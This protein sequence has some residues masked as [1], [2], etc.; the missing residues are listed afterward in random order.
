[1][2]S[3]PTGTVTFLFTDIEGSTRRWDR[4][5]K[6]MRLAL[7]RHD[8]LLQ[9]VIAQQGGHVF[10]TVG[11]AFHAAF[12]SAT[13]ALAGAV[14]VQRAL[15]VE[16]WTVF[17]ADLEPLRVRT[18]LHTGAAEL[19]DGDYFGPPLNRTARLL[20]AGHGGQI[21]L[22]LATQQLV[23]DEL[24]GDTQLQD[25]G[26]HRLKDLGHSE[27]IFRLVVQGLPDVV[28]PPDTAETL[29]AAERAHFDA[30]LLPSECPYRG[31][32]AFRE[33]DAPFFFG[34]ESFTQL[35]TETAAGGPMVGVIGPSGSGKS[36]VVF[37]GLVPALRAEG[38]VN[39]GW[40]I[41][42]LRPGAQPYFALAGTLLPLLEGEL[43][44]T[45]RLIKIGRL[46]GALQSGDLS[47][48]RVMA[49]IAEK[50]PSD[51]RLM[52]VADQF[53]ELY[54]LCRDERE[55]RAFQDLLFAAAFEP[56][57]APTTFLTL[58]LRAD[59]M[60]HA[61]AY[62]PFADAIQRHD[63]KLGPMT[64]DELARAIRLPAEKQGRAF[65]TGLVE[66]IMDDVGEKAG[67]LPLLEFA[68]TKLWE[69]QAAGWLTH[70]AYEQ[71]G[72]VEGAVARQ[73]DAVHERL[74]DAERERARR[75]FVQL[76]QPGEGTEDTRRLATRSELGEDWPLVRKLADA[77]LVV[78]SRDE[79]GHE[80]AEVV[81]EALIRSW[82]RL[83]EWINADRRFRTWQERLRYA[84]RQWEASDHDEGALL[85]GAP[86]A[87]AEGW[88]PQR[89]DELSD[90]ERAYIAAG[91]ELRDRRTHERQAQLER[92]AASA[93]R[94]RQQALGLS[95]ALI[96]AATMTVVAFISRQRSV[97]DARIATARELAAAAVSSLDV[98]PERSTLLAL[99]AM[100]TT[101]N[102]DSRILP[103]AGSILHQAVAS[104]HTEHA[105]EHD[106]MVMAIAYSPD[107]ELVATASKDNSAKLWEAASGNLR[108]KLA[109]HSDEVGYAVYSPDGRILATSSRDK[110][111]MLWNVTTGESLQVLSGHEGQLYELAFSPDGQRI[112]TSSNDGT[113]RVWDV[114]TG[115]EIHRLSGHDARVR[116]VITSAD[117][118]LIA[119]ASTDKTVGLW[120][121]QTGRLVHRFDD[122]NEEAT[123][124][125]FSPDSRSIAIAYGQRLPVV[126]IRD[127]ATGEQRTRFVG[128]KKQVT[129][130]AFSR[131]GNY[132]ATAS[133]DA[134]AKLWDVATGSEIR[135]LVG[136]IQQLNAVA[137]SPDGSQLATAS[138][139]GTARLWEFA[140]GRLH[141]TL[142]GHS[143][144]IGAIVF[145]PNGLHVATAAAE[146]AARIWDVQADRETATIVGPA[147][148]GEIAQSPDG[149][150]L[151]IIWDD[152]EI[153]SADIVDA[154]SGRH[155]ATL[156]GHSQRLWQLDFSPDGKR[157]V[158][159]SLDHTAKIWDTNSG[160][161]LMTLSG[162]TG[163]L[164]GV[165]YS[166]DG[167]AIATVSADRTGIIWDALTGEKRLILTGFFA[168]G[169]EPQFN[170]DGTKL[171]TKSN[172][173]K[174]YGT[175]AIVWD[176]KNGYRAYP[177]P[178]QPNGVVARAVFSPDGRYLAISGLEESGFV[179]L[180]DAE[181]GRLARDLPVGPSSGEY[182][183]SFSNDGTM[184]AS[185]GVDGTVTIWGV[186]T[187]QVLKRLE[188][189]G[190]GAYVAWS[191]D[192]NFIIGVNS[193]GST[194]VWDVQSGMETFTL[195]GQYSRR[196]LVSPDS[197]RLITRGIDNTVNI[198]LLRT[199][200][201]VQ[202]AR[203]RLTRGLT[204]DECR[205]YLHVETC[206][207]SP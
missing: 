136:H 164:N 23:R 30:E 116:R 102:I 105:L 68:L 26:V 139:D 143:S 71:I 22:T 184:V 108:H 155:L 193:D 174:G 28:A 178:E 78:T 170:A 50:R 17:G 190:V 107:G 142:R 2:I 189:R 150:R 188:H 27:H 127:V 90:A 58:T 5:L 32:H 161:E 185:K 171:V 111:A 21:L 83:R 122:P 99:Q 86:L 98:D 192:A 4:Q 91:L 88:L 158:T 198:S 73:A 14:E 186:D 148:A 54:T 52:L 206:P 46:A 194:K 134:T 163:D 203:S 11:D 118:H 110:T 138:L 153:H 199:S 65:E 80:T 56:Q 31:L 57:G 115:Q 197:R 201:L 95:A 182:G 89:G 16:D 79:A 135:T 166:P 202:M 59:F 168:S 152:F 8:E 100:S 205:Q 104:M 82:E 10:K 173:P 147:T 55:Q 75:V 140:T 42:D 87:E 156:T 92:E 133:G 45:D 204:T 44:E 207:P 72:R 149:S 119:T 64:R 49:R 48:D 130:V 47:I 69:H 106:E 172:S 1:M 124:L 63:V 67:A 183:V 113:A 131:D 121:A 51:G 145:A 179:R 84:L 39:G 128:H 85:R 195:Y 33:A 43:D 162:H 37:A 137:W 126:A 66:R 36:S 187:G 29:R 60:G 7:A 151:A 175:E 3:L 12:A 77:R 97:H 154:M 96:V 24:P 123:D 200:D 159:N 117:G 157:I 144:T 25:L 125:E 81:H 93:R 141:R 6:A 165:E 15:L 41:L 20:A 169:Y 19:R 191:P 181:S 94:L 62:R 112:T 129:G 38:A 101:Q 180:W 40:T 70:D 76:V 61:L 176:L 103:E 13:D 177:I 114:S 9:A 53:E 74:T 35:L 109:G 132:V 146:N 120:D 167:K 196:P 18:A 34:R 160:R